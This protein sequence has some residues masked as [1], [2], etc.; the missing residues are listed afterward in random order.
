[1]IITIKDKEPSEKE[2][3]VTIP[4]EEMREYADKAA[5]SLGGDLELKGFRKGKAPLEIIKEHLGEQRIWEQA[6]E[7]AFGTTYAQAVKEHGLAAVSAPQVTVEKLA[8]NNEFIY[9]AVVAI[10]PDVELPEIYKI[11]KKIREKEKREVEVSEKEMERA[12]EWLKKSRKVEEINDEFAKEVGG[13]ENVAALRKN[14]FEGLKQEKEAKE[15]ERI[16]LLILQEIAK[17]ASIKLPQS[18]LD[19]ERGKMM[20]EL[21]NRVSQMGLSMEDYLTHVKKTKEEIQE[22]WDER[23]KERVEAGVILQAI[24]EQEKVQISEEE[25]EERVKHYLAHYP[26]PQEA[27]KELGSAKGLRSYVQGILRNEKVFALLDGAPPAAGQA[28][29]ESTEVDRKEN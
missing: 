23:A 14:I 11:A 3:H 9:T 20:R 4:A 2:I 10:F 24:G 22:G 21:E 6:A 18:L 27:E 17:E 16:R 29:P 1:M 7:D 8:P 5:K 12:L 25:V 15:Q 26:S 28:A 13:F 19:E